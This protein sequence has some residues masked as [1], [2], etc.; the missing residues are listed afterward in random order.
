MKSFHIE[1]TAT[2]GQHFA[3]IYAP[4]RLRRRFPENCVQVVS[5]AE[6]ALQAAN[7]DKSFYPAQVIGPSRSS[8]GFRL[9]YLV[10]WLDEGDSTP[11]QIE[12][13]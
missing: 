12:A 7:P 3:L 6:M 13:N 8:E 9:Y 4:R 5:S 11:N 1:E 2:V 10:R